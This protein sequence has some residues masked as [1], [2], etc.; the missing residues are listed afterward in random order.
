MPGDIESTHEVTYFFLLGSKPFWPWPWKGAFMIVDLK[1]VIVQ[2]PPVINDT[3]SVPF[4]TTGGLPGS[5][6]STA[7]SQVPTSCLSTSCSGRGLG[8]G[9]I[10]W[11]SAAPATSRPSP[12]QPPA[13][14]RLTLF[15]ILD[16]L[17]RRCFE[18][19]TGARAP[20]VVPRSCPSIS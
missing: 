9:G 17:L 20:T 8:S 14:A 7:A 4:V 15:N 3:V 19:T 11:A 18:H 1:S 5:T 6:I 10:S 12:R 13:S 2:R 16:L